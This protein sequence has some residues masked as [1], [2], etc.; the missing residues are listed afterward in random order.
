MGERYGRLEQLE[1]RAQMLLGVF[2]SKGVLP[3]EFKLTHSVGDLLT[4]P[5]DALE[6]KAERKGACCRRSPTTS[7]R[8]IKRLLATSAW[9]QP[10]R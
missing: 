3:L 7:R 8:C 10:P 2:S 9:R 4:Q 5:L 1:H 6:Q